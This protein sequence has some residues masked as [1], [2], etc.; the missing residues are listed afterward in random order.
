[1]NG[2]SSQ[3]VIGIRE[4]ARQGEWGVPVGGQKFRK[5]GPV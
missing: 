5:Y 3:A 4:V 2:L 1:M